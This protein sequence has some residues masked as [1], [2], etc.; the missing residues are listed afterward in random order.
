MFTQLSIM[1]ALIAILA[2][3]SSAPDTTTNTNARGINPVQ[4]SE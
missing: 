3:G 1:I 2:V 4:H